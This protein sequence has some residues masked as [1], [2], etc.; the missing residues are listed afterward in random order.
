MVKGI[1]ESMKET[2]KGGLVDSGKIQIT[3]SPLW[4]GEDEK[5]NGNCLVDGDPNCTFI[6]ENNENSYVIIRFVDAPQSISGIKL[7]PINSNYYPLS[8]S[9][10]GSENG[11]YFKT[12]YTSHEPLCDM[13]TNDEYRLCTQN[14]PKIYNIK[15]TPRYEYFKITQ[16]GTTTALGALRSDWERFVFS[17]RLL[18]IEFYTTKPLEDPTKIQIIRFSHAFSFL[19]IAFEK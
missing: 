2:I 14:S 19:F 1:F 16:I 18:S 5:F 8:W 15:S 10:Q 13:H 11:K 4:V 17:F 9:L 7:V 12:I 3:S 6:T